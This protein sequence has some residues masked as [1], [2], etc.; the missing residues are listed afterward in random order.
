MLPEDSDHDVP[1]NGINAM[2][3]ESPTRRLAA[4]RHH[5]SDYEQKF[6]EHFR[7][8]MPPS[9]LHDDWTPYIQHPAQ[10]VDTPT[11]SRT[12]SRVERWLERNG[13]HWFVAR[14]PRPSPWIDPSFRECGLRDA[15]A[16][17]CPG[18]LPDALDVDERNESGLMTL[19]QLHGLLANGSGQNHHAN[20]ATCRGPVSRVS[21]CR[22]TAGNMGS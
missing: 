1:Q 4:T 20:D 14:P 8:A 21:N 22:I 17:G 19:E 15:G 9:P 3:L 18:E 6:L 11:S 16:T 13:L 7:A 5:I 2:L 10:V 12:F